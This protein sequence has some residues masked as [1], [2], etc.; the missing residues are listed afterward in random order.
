M[1][2]EKPS[3]SRSSTR[4]ARLIAPLKSDKAIGQ[5]NEVID[6]SKDES[7]AN[8]DDSFPS[9]KEC[10]SKRPF[11]RSK[12]A[13]QHEDPKKH[14]TTVKHTNFVA[15][16]KRIQ[17]MA[18]KIQQMLHNIEQRKGKKIVCGYKY[19]LECNLPACSIIVEKKESEVNDVLKNWTCEGGDLEKDEFF[20]ADVDLKTF[21]D[22]EERS[23]NIIDTS[24]N[25]LGMFTEY[26]DA[27]NIMV[28]NLTKLKDE[29]DRLNEAM[30]DVAVPSTDEFN[31]KREQLIQSYTNLCVEVNNRNE[32]LQ[33]VRRLLMMRLR[34]CFG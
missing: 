32:C 30:T 19:R 10:F 6:I 8:N 24:I 12:R 15:I 23:K 3:T 28:R 16:S 4:R 20:F 29:L 33:N 27:L 14:S 22:I 18:T 26:N 2:Q 1:V 21:N 7:T 34:Q 25:Y 9:T 31:E 13:R 17:E 11:K 5:T